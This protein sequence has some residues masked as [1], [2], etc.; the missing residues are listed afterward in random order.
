MQELG[1]PGV[2]IGSHINDW[3]LDAP[4]L[5]PFFQV[6]WSIVTHCPTSHC[7]VDVCVGSRRVGC[8]CV[9]PPMGHAIGWTHEQV[10]V[11]MACGHAQ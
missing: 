10:L 4:E 6:S 7:P 3:N 9:R 5:L 2:Q 1:F 11:A 8:C